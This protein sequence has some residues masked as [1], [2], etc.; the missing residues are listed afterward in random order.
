MRRVTAGDGST[1]LFNAAPLRCVSASAI[2]SGAA[3]TCSA[4]C[5]PSRTPAIDAL[6]VAEQDWRAAALGEPAEQGHGQSL[7]AEE[8]GEFAVAGLRLLVGQ[9]PD[10][11]AAVLQLEQR[12]YRRGFGADL[13][14]G[15]YLSLGRV[16]ADPAQE[17]LADR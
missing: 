17:R 9:D 5:G 10:H 2:A 13:V 15:R 4:K 11:A 14:S 6:A 1:V 16:G 8:R 12:A 7:H 3:S